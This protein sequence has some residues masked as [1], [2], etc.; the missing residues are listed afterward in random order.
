MERLA[1]KRILV[2]GASTGIGREAAR[3]AVISGARVV[4]AARRQALL[5][6]AVAEAGGGLVVPCDVRDPSSCTEVVQASVEWLGGLDALVYSSA[7]VPFVR[8]ADATPQLW[9][10][11]MATNV[12]GASLV[13]QAAQPHLAATAGRVVLI[14][15]SSTG[16][17]VPGLGVYACTKAALEELVR[18]WRSEYSG[19]GFVSARV[20]ST[21]G[22]EVGKD[23]DPEVRQHMGERY[24][25]G[26]YDLDNGPGTMT[27]TECASSVLM[28]LTVPVCLREFTATAAPDGEAARVGT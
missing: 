10:D 7:M 6:A 23:S 1:G 4:F 27:V 16:R 18:V 25:R 22:T 20:G 24:V 14:S 26:G 9:A 28:A 3:L 13:V 11:I 21:L 19:I 17:P 15:A 2:V 12:T 8:V 5:E